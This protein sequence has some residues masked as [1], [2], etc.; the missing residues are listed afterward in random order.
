M[1]GVV[2][3]SDKSGLE[4]LA[5]QLLEREVEIYSTGG[6]LATLQ[7]AGLSAR[8]VSDL[9]GFPEILSGRVKTLHPHVHGG[10]LARTRVQSDMDELARHGV[11]PIGVVVVNL[12][13]FAESIAHPGATLETALENIDIGGPT[14]IRAAA[15]NF[16]D[17]VV[18][19]DP[20]DYGPVME[21]WQSHGAV[22]LETRQWLSAKA[23]AHVSAYDSLIAGYLRGSDD[24]FPQ[25]MTLPLEKIEDLRYGEN[26]HQRGALYRQ[27]TADG[28]GFVERLRQVGGADLSYNNV[29]DAD[30]ATRCVSDFQGPTIAIIKHGNPCG[31]ATNTDLSLAFEHALM[32][33]PVSAYGGVVGVNREVDVAVA[34]GMSKTFFQLIVAPSFTPEARAILQRKKKLRLLEVGEMDSSWEQPVTPSKLDLKRVGG[35]LLLQTPD[36]VPPDEVQTQVVTRR[37][38]TLEEATD[39]LFAWRAVKHIHSNAVALAKD[40]MLVSMGAGQPS[41]VDSVRIAVRKADTRAPG[42]V[43][44][45][46]AFFPFGDGVEEAGKAGV[47]AI[48]QPG[49]SVRDDEVIRVADRYGMAMVFTGSRHF[50]H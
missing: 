48:I 43:L 46:D 41:R 15:K 13:P 27:I 44:A 26:P 34:E 50:R 38:P 25:T 39:L 35:G 19:T 22:S 36:A 16:T 49:G 9:T 4:D 21:E 7:T 6:T 17:V 30:L 47:S 10:I 32:G 29:L 3:V 8:S 20:A 2:S 18:L 45:S 1:R 11:E 40:L 24:L 28:S 42:S 23:F 31:L 5:R 37:Q 33:D 14:L 12:Y